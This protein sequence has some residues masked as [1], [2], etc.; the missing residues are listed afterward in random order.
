ML[1]QQ[2]EQNGKVGPHCFSN[3]HTEKFSVAV[4]RVVEGELVIDNMEFNPG[5]S[6]SESEEFQELASSVEAEVSAS[7]FYFGLHLVLQNK[8]RLMQNLRFSQQ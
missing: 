2:K 7:K 5:L 3:S 1:N 8:D 4:P 6:M